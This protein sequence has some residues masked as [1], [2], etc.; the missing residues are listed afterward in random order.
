VEGIRALYIN[1]APVLHTD[2]FLYRVGEEEEE[3]EIMDLSV[4]S[5]DFLSFYHFGI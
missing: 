3:E 1:E 2:V 5:I 4:R